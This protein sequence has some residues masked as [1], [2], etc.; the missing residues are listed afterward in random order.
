M[1]EGF[2]Y[3]P[4]RFRPLGIGG[5]EVAPTGLAGPF[6]VLASAVDVPAKAPQK[7]F[8]EGRFYVIPDS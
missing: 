4:A 8:D 6:L 1:T 5:P 2:L 7:E 3:F